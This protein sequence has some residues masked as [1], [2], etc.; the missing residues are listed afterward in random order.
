MAGKLFF[1]P[2]RPSGFS[3]LKRL[4]AA[5]RRKTAGELRAWLEAQDVYTLNR[6]VRKSF[7]RNPST[8]NNI[9]DVWECDSVDVQGLSK[10]N[11]GIKYILSVIDAF[12]KFRASDVEDG[13]LLSRHRFNVFLKTTDTRNPYAGDRSGYR[14]I[15]VRNSRIY[16][17]NTCCSVKA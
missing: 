1:D 14:R 7:P 5:A 13:S 8:V 6:P 11:H 16:R 9:M 17:F 15:G 4:H 2:K 12:S 3:T 10:Y